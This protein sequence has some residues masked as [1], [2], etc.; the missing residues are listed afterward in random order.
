MRQSIKISK[1]QLKKCR[2][3]SKVLNAASYGWPTNKE[4]YLKHLNSTI[5]L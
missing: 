1:T 2:R 5:N 3:P 4:K